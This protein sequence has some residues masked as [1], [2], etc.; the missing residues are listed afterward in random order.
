MHFSSI[1]R[2]WLTNVRWLVWLLMAFLAVVHAPAGDATMTGRSGPPLLPPL[3]LSPCHLYSLAEEV[4]CGVHEVYENREAASGRRVPVH[5]AVLPPLRR[6][7]SPDPLFILAGGPGQGT[8]SFGAVAARHFKQV[9]RSRAIVLVD[10]RGTGASNPLECLRHTDEMAAFGWSWD[11]YLGDARACLAEID[12]DPRHYTHAAALVDLDEIRQRLG[13][14]QIN[15]WG[16]SWGTRAGMLYA[17]SY[18]HAVRSVVLDGAV[19]FEEEFPRLVARNAERAMN[20]LLERCA[21]DPVCA[22]TFPQPRAE[23][24][25]LLTRLAQRP[26]T[27][28]MRHPRTAQPVPVTLTRDTVAEVV[29]VALYTPLDAA[30]LLQTIQHAARGDYG[31]LAAQYAHSAS[32]TTDDMALGFTMSVLCSEDLPLAARDL[33]ADSRNTFV[34]SSYA[35]AWRSRC[36]GWPNGPSIM[37]DRRSTSGA[38]ALILSGEHD[39]VTPPSSGDA[40]GRRFPNHLHVVVPGAAH[41]ASFTGCVPG[42][43]A[44]FLERGTTGLNAACVASVPLPPI[45]VSDAGG[46]P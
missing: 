13:Y 41:N 15:I 39:P 22:S 1:F 37:L 42:L 44:T 14:A 11:L 30:R 46:R 40:M 4:L 32:M 34:G 8:R 21:A 31:P 25:A 33:D 43:I 45:V 17:L 2:G 7:A 35:G 18:P 20:L 9:R 24:E 5:V 38:P 19:S 3:L 36:R 12:A 6:S 16:G 23:L 10:L 26:I 28:T 29:R 27:V